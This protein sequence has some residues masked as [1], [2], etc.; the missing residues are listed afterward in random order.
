[1]PFRPAVTLIEVMLVLIVLGVLLSMAAPSFHRSVEQSWADVAGANLRAIWTAQRLYWLEHRTYTAGLSELES[2]GLVDPAVVSATQ[3][4]R[5]E[6]SSADATSFT[7]KAT[8][9]GSARWSGY[10]K[11]DEQGD[12]WGD[13][14]AWGE[15]DIEPGFL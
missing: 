13:V 14:H 9:S 11:I 8:R 2:L 1:M 6:I 7:A 12:M 3:P 15:P 5:Y 10:F 4:Y